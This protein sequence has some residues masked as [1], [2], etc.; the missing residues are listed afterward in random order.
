MSDGERVAF[1]LI[2]Q[3]LS[4]PQN[5]II[6]I[7]E[8][9]LH[10]HKSIQTRLWREIQAARPDCLFVYMT[11]DVEFAASLTEAQKIWLKSYDGAV[12]EWEEV[13]SVEEFPEALLLQILGTRQHILFVEGELESLDVE[14][15]RLLYPDHLVIPRKGCEQVILATRALRDAKLETW[16]EA[17]GIIDRDRRHVGEIATLKKQGIET[18]DVAEVENLFCVPEVLHLVAQSQ[19]L[20]SGEEVTR[21]QN[22]V[23]KELEKEKKAQ[24]SSHVAQEIKWRLNVFDVKKQGANELQVELESLAQA[25]DVSAIYRERENEVND[26]LTTRNYLG[27][28]RLFNRKGLPAQLSE[29]FGVASIS[30]LIINLA[31]SGKQQ[32]VRQALRPHIPHF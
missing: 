3:A 23:F 12:W 22:F 4:A 25:I 1:Y 18:L 14:L 27:A 16:K 17:H 6:I 28:L 30:K 29:V 7:D 8:P 19:G 13:P 10:L 21:A 9:E 20:T 5:G 2:G 11:H 31:N 15:F 24:I 26:V 32:E